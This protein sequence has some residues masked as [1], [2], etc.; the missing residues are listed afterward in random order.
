LLFLPP[1]T[2]RPINGAVRTKPADLAI[3]HCVANADEAIV[4]VRASHAAWL[5]RKA[6]QQR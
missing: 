1:D 4:L 3:P 2:F 6:Q 5:D